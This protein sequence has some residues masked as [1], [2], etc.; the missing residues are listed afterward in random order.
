MHV[1]RHS[2]VGLIVLISFSIRS[3]QAQQQTMTFGSIPSLDSLEECL[4]DPMNP[5]GMRMRAAYYLRHIHS[6][7]PTKQENVVSVLE[8]GLLERRHGSLLRHEFAY[9]MGQ[10]KDERVRCRVI[11]SERLSH[12]NVCFSRFVHRFLAVVSCL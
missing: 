3:R 6:V 11:A 10:M 5:I 8:K 1:V 4:S 9:V 12:P 7:T 2:Y